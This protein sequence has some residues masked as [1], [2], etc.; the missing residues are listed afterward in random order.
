MALSY[1][2]CAL[3]R[4]D[5]PR[6]LTALL[7]AVLDA[8]RARGAQWLAWG[9]FED[10]PLGRYL[11]FKSHKTLRSR[12]YRVEWP[13]AGGAPDLDGRGLTMELGSL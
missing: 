2:A 9:F 5:D 4:D 12:I 11:N 13:G 1:G 7:D 10:D 6:V 3:V 8:A